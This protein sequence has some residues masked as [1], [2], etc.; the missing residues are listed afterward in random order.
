MS[1]ATSRVEEGGAPVRLNE[2]TAA[3]FGPGTN[4]PPPDAPP[5]YLTRITIEKVGGVGPLG[6]LTA[7]PAVVE[8]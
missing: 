3:I 4:F 5:W 7:E 1:S 2:L 6:I 8:D